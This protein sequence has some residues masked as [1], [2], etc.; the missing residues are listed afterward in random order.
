MLV[1]VAAFVRFVKD[2]DGIPGV[3]VEL[4]GIAG[5][6]HLRMTEVLAHLFGALAQQNR[7]TP[8]LQCVLGDIHGE[9]HRRAFLGDRTTA[10]ALLVV[11][12]RE[13]R[14]DQP[15][16]E[17]TGHA[18]RIA[19]IDRRT[20]DEHIRFVGFLQHRTQVILDS[21]HAIRLG[22]LQ[23]ARETGLAAFVIQVIEVDLLR[24]CAGFLCAAHG[25][26]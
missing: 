6:E 2:R 4:V 14:E 18:G 19:E 12:V 23:L 16:H 1:V 17:R 26:F 13:M 20:D 11:V 7:V 15:L 21:A 22:V 5:A 3:V 9:D 24:F 25:S 10:V 8:F